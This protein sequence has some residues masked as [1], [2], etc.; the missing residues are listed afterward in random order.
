[1]ASDNKIYYTVW[2]GIGL[3]IV[4]WA[5]FV[6]TGVYIVAYFISKFW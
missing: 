5:S 2:A 1:M 4:L 3:A 6:G